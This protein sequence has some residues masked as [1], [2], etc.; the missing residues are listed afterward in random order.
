MGTHIEINSDVVV[1]GGGH[2]GVFLAKSL[3]QK[4]YDVVLVDEDD[5]VELCSAA[6]RNLV[7]PE[8]AKRTIVKFADAVPKV[9]YIHGRLVEL[10][11][12]GAGRVENS[13]SGYTVRAKA[14]VLCT[15]Q[16]YRSTAPRASSEYLSG[17]RLRFYEHFAEQVKESERIAIIG[18]GPVGVEFAAEVVSEY[19]GK[20]VTLINSESRVL[21]TT[22][23][24]TSRVAQAFFDRHGVSVLHN[25]RVEEDP[26]GNG[27]LLS[28][29][30]RL[31][32]DLVFWAT[33]GKP[34][35]QYMAKHWS[36]VLNAKGEIEVDST[37]LVKGSKNVFAFGDV[38]FLDNE[39]KLAWLV[40]M[41]WPVCAYNV[42]QVVKNRSGPL[43]RY[44]THPGDP[45]M[46]ITL[47]P[48]EGV[49]QL[50]H[51]GTV[52]WG[53]FARMAKS[54]DMMSGRFRKDLGLDA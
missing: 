10:A 18:A 31:A 49:F 19:P 3:S 47:G 11:E 20:P 48:K 53:W 15:G 6:V 14:V 7:I 41:Q 29:G 23:P 5:Y 8:F 38:A 21:P 24:K 25:T 54:K 28:N 2:G 37:F 22:T 35:S 16:S 34:N 13:E 45:R 17:D 26:E 32:A 36:K 1:Y 30:E 40:G 52:S 33:G 12:D 51:V 9:Q 4:G 42:E 43:K 39:P 46:G 44:T 50:P 27:L